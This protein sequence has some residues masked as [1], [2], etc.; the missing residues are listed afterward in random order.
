MQKSIE[1]IKKE[2]AGLYPDTEISSF[3]YLLIGAITG[4]S[5]TEIIVNKYTNFSNEQRDLLNS[6]IEKLKIYTPIQYVLG[7]CE[8]MGLQFEVNPSVLIPRPET[9]ELVE[10]ILAS[11]NNTNSVSILDIGTGSGCIAVSLKCKLPK[12][13]VTAYDLSYDALALA[14]KNAEI[15]EVTVDFRQQDILCPDDEKGEWEII[16]SNPPYI[17]DAEK[18]EIQPNV[19]NFEPH[20]ALFVPDN[21]PLLF[22]RKIIEFAAMHLKAGGQLFFEIHRDR[23]QEVMQLLSEAG[24][25]EIELRKDLS[26]NDRMLKAGKKEN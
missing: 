12:A 1:Y 4:Y 6:F 23:G 22:Y 11:Q 21:D 18:I 16:V 15:N 19:L 3:T 10:W 24:F 26:G 7:Q 14:R 2:L 20:L 13:F 17:P 5:R 25:A 8:F 9:E